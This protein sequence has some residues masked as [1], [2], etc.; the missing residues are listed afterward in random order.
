MSMITGFTLLLPEVKGRDPDLILA[1]E[2]R[3]D[4]LE[5]RGFQQKVY[6]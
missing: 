4:R 2:I 1:Q 3:L 5:K 6:P